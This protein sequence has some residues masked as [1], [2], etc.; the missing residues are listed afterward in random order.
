MPSDKEIEAAKK[1]FFGGEFPTYSK[2]YTVTNTGTAPASV[3]LPPLKQ[4]HE[5]HSLLMEALEAAEKVRKPDQYY[6]TMVRDSNGDIE[7]RAYEVL[8][9]DKG[10]TCHVSDTISK[11]AV[12]YEVKLPQPPK[13]GE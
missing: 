9:D 7:F 10:Y 13:E 8:P 5:L 12:T 3:V 1:V 2:S 6:L 4:C 11:E